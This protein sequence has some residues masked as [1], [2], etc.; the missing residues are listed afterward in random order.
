MKE[1]PYRTVAKWYDKI[2]ESMNS[3]LRLLGLRMFMPKS[4]MAILD[5][6]C[7]TG[8]HLDLYRRYHCKLYGIDA[9]P[10]MLD[11]AKRRLGNEAD[12]R[13]GDASEMPYGDSSFDLVTAMLVLHEMN[14]PTRIAVMNEMK[15]VLKDDGRILLI[16]FHPGPIQPFQGWLTKIIILLSELAAGRVHFKNYRHFM[17]IKGMPTLIDVSSLKIE[18]ERIVSGGALALFLLN[19]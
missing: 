8:V 14:H 12:L 15:R 4:E 5:I 13:L 11:M 2:F 6:G 9:S 16:D 18:K 17:S 1:D 10:S 7:G 19:K 3:G